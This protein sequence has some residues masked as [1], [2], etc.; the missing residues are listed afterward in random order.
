[1]TK[2]KLTTK[3]KAV[4]RDDKMRRLDRHYSEYTGSEISI[5]H[6]FM[7]FLISREAKGCTKATLDAYKRF[8]KKLIA[9][10]NE[11]NPVDVLQDDIGQVAFKLSLGKVSEQTVNHYLRSYRAF[12]NYCEEQGYLDGFKCSFKEITPPVKEVYTDK[13]I[14]K[15]LVR[16]K[17]D[18]FTEFRNYITIVL[19][20]GTAA[21]LNTILN[22]KLK[23]VDI[24]QRQI[25]FNTIKNRTPVIMP[26]SKFACMELKEYIK[27]YRTNRY[28]DNGALV[29]IS[30][31]EYLLCNEYG[32][33]LT[34]S[35]MEKSIKLY[36]KRRGVNKSS[37]HLFRHTYAKNWIKNGGDI[38]SLQKILTH[39]EMDMVKR[40]A[41]LY[42]TDLRKKADEF[43]TLSQ[44]KRRSGKTLNS[45]K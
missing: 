10:T 2:K 34:R 29:D 35:G 33:Q 30:E 36:N 1:M 5:R 25:V 14:D 44:H 39:S 18:K 38:I 19:L 23:D 43:S 3:P 27:R 26:L 4:T 32:E 40:Y 28:D 6:A 20:T 16:P 37:I 8:Y 15:L 17:A 21:R 22:I 42:N 7:G 9:F 24:E 31:E 41:N 13:E 11:E 45:Q 12:G